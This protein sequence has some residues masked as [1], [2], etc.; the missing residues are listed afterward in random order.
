M[1]FPNYIGKKRL[2]TKE[3]VIT[4]LTAAASEINGPLPCRDA[5]YNQMKKGRM[6]W[7][8]SRRVL[9]YFHS[10]ARAWLAVGV[11][12]SRVS[13][14][15]ID[16]S[17]EED[18]YLLDNAGTLTLKS[19][20]ARLGRSYAAVRARLGKTFRISA[21]ANPGFL[22]AAELAKEYGCPYQRVRTALQEGKIIGRYDRTRNRWQVDLKDITPVAEEILKAPK[23]HSYRNSPSD[24]GDYYQRYGLMR[25]LIGGR[26]MVIS[27]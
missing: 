15:N 14:K 5:L 10:M 27:V 9:E 24:L 3:R 22:S 16:W 18:I 2:W 23:L 6:D 21:R 25:K 7:P 8:T 17:V 4:A 1:P 26:V 19:I 13:L 20:A 12:N 11:D